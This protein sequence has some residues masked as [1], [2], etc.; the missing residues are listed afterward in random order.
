MPLYISIFLLKVLVFL[1]FRV[2]NAFAKQKLLSK[3]FEIFKN[4]SLY[5]TPSVA[6][7]VLTNIY[8][9]WITITCGL[10]VKANRDRFQKIHKWH[11]LNLKLED[12][13]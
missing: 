1:L 6:A 7:S 4:T 9:T 3:A 11:F 8:S 2:N 13:N 12:R 5:R 10:K